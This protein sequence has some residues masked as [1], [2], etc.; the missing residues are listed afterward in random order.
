MQI[1]NY[2]DQI[3]HDSSTD[4]LIKASLEFENLRKECLKAM[5][6]HTAPLHPNQAIG[7]KVFE[8]KNWIDE[9]TSLR[10]SVTRQPWNTVQEISFRVK[11]K[12][13]GYIAHV[14]IN[15]DRVNFELDDEEQ[16][17]DPGIK[18]PLWH[19]DLEDYEL[20][21]LKFIQMIETLYGTIV[22]AE[23]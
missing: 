21:F 22:V 2:T 14:T 15:P 23:E 13:N 11:I 1:K 12:A 17:P 10:I 8:T 7:I 16:T 3:V 4:E 9:K 5:N 6:E 18:L 20:P 19:K